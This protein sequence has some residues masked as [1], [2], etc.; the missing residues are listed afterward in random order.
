MIEDKETTA[1]VIFEPKMVYN[2]RLLA[3]AFELRSAISETYLSVLRMDVD[4]W[5]KDIYKIPQHKNR[6]L[7]GYAK[8]NVGDIRAIE[9]HHVKYDV[10]EAD[11]S[12]I[13]SHAGIFITVDNEP[14][15]GGKKLATL[16]E[17]VTEDF[18]LL[19][20]RNRLVNLAQRNLVELNT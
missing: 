9:L 18:F 5:E 10:Q 13:S 6:R 3:S 8:L 15:I 7:F 1:R 19:A 12:K 14:L 11:N 4:G 20:I 2:G 16:P 17:G